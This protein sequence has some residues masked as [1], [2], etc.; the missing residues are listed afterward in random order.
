MTNEEEINRLIGEIGRLYESEN[1]LEVVV[2]ASPLTVKYPNVP[3]ILFFLGAA[4][5]GL[6]QFEHALPLLE[7]LNSKFGANPLGLHFLA[8]TN[9]KLGFSDQAYSLLKKAILMR[10]SVIE[11]RLTL[12]QIC[13]DLN[14]YEEAIAEARTCLARNPNFDPARELLAESLVHLEKFEL[15]LKELHHFESAHT[16][17][18]R[19]PML[20]FAVNYRLGNQVQAKAHLQEARK[21]SEGSSEKRYAQA[22]LLLRLGFEAESLQ[23]N[24]EAYK[25]NPQSIAVIKSLDEAYR[26]IG[27]FSECEKLS[28][29]SLL[30]HPEESKFYFNFAY[31]HKATTEDQWLFEQAEAILKSKQTSLKSQSEIWFSLGKMF[32]DLSD[33]RNAANAFENAHDLKPK[34]DPRER[35]DSSQFFS[36]Q[37]RILSLLNTQLLHQRSAVASPSTKPIFVLGMLRSGTTLIEQVLSRHPKVV[38]GGEI[39]FFLTHR[40]RA[41]SLLSPLDPHR[42]IQLRDEYIARLHKIGPEAVYVTDKLPAN[43]MIVGLLYLLFPQAKVIHCLRNAGDVGVSIYATAIANPT[44]FAHKRGDIV[45]VYRQY[46]KSMK[47]WQELIPA[48]QYQ[49][50][51]LDFRYESLVE[52]PEIETRRLLD[53]CG[54]EWDETCL[55]TQGGNQN[56]YTPSGWQVRQPIYKSAINRWRNYE[57][58]FPEFAHMNAEF[59]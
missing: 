10:P 59:N 52:N 35:F 49:N 2:R 30:A 9:W 28:R 6:G 39:D 19:I 14:K 42:L 58:Y 1:F 3:Q 40:D 31:S 56:V 34:Y 44:P 57:P 51:V 17:N 43:A 29:Q 55:E 25:F 32:D 12:G 22:K 46:R 24:E 11:M 48:A 45:A 36:T 38:A 15:A 5:V 7:K 26:R 21:V 27:K 54:L 4:H 23:F 16:Q 37:D 41:L 50:F 33:Y 47:H 53:F 13:L 18:A 8:I 20:L